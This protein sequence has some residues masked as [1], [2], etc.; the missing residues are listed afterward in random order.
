MLYEICSSQWFADASI[1]VTYLAIT[2]LNAKYRNKIYY[3]ISSKNFQNTGTIVL[4]P[5]F[6]MQ[7]TKQNK[8]EHFTTSQIV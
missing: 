6:Q 5:H 7:K 3:K 1:V 8:K 4:E 2:K